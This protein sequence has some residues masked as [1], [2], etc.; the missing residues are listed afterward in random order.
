MDFQQR[1]PQ[2]C[3]FGFGLGAKSLLGH[4][5]AQLL[6]DCPDC[7]RKSDVFDLLNKTKHVTRRLAAKAVI[8]LPRRM[9]RKRWRLLF[10]KRAQAGII[11][12]ARLPKTDIAADDADNVGLLLEGLREV[13]GKC[14]A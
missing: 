11:L 3:V 12:R 4:R 6:R 5:H 8:K 10:M 2:S 13:V 9:H 1:R 7:F 14:H